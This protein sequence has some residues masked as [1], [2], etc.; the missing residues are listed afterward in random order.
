MNNYDL[1]Q[2]E[3]KERIKQTDTRHDI[4]MVFFAAVVFVLFITG[5]NMAFNDCLNL[6]VC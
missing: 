2:S 1:S 3:I 5:S 6:G 4:K